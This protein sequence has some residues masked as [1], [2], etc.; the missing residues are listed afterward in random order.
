MRHSSRK[1][2]P[3]YE[4]ASILRRRSRDPLR[5]TK[6]EADTALLDHGWREEQ[7]QGLLDGLKL[8]DSVPDWKHEHLQ[9]LCDWC[10]D[11]R[12]NPNAA[13]AQLEFVAYDLCG[14]HNALGMALKKARTRE[15]AQRAVDPSRASL[16]K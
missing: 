5:L 9:R 10:S 12:K 15:A 1:T 13:E 2:Q 6:V 4:A 11:R 3:A 8:T 7:A 16:C 14:T